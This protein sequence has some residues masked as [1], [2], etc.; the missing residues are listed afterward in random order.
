MEKPEQ[1][2]FAEFLDY[3]HGKCAGRP[4]PTRA[5]IDPLDI[6]RLLPHVYLVESSWHPAERA[7]TQRT[8]VIDASSGEVTRHAATMQA[9]T[10]DEYRQLLGECGFEEMESHPSLTGGGHESQPGMVA[11]LARSG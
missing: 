11:L 8:F 9:Y 1:S 4:M 3:W 7:A 6:P 5:D 10:D 2:L